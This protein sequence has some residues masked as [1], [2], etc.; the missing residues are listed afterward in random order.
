[1]SAVQSVARAFA[2]LQCLSG[3]PAGL[4]EIAE[5]ADLPKSTV[6]RLLATL[7]E[8]GAVTQSDAGGEYRMGPL[9]TELAGSVTPTRNLANLAHQTLVEV[10]ED[11]G[12]AAG[13][14]VLD[15][16]GQ[17]LYLDQVDAEQDVQVRDWSGEH[18]PFHCVASGLILMAGAPPELV[19]QTLA[20]PLPRYTDNTLVDPTEI[21]AR[22]DA[23]RDAGVVWTSAEFSSEL[24]SVAAP[25]LDTEGVVLAAIHVHGP[26]YRFPGER[27]TAEIEKIVID[28]AH[29]ISA[30]LSH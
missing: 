11:V 8:L 22:L 13:L 28:A 23:T 2:I 30:L 4:S 16:A 3:G 18:V 5:R 20:S 27:R 6:A 21:L 25:I 15:E 1:M 29:R 9:V 10:V 24:T 26:S 17:V 14:S 12:E 19:R 7:Q